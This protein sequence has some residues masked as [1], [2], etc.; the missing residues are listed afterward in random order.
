M[1][2]EDGRL[3]WGGRSVYEDLPAFH[4]QLVYLGH[5]PPLK[6]DLTARENLH[7]SLIHI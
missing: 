1:H 2:L 3:L 6:A 7:L 5:A 4:S